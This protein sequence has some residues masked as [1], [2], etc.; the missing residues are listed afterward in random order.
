M[1][2]QSDFRGA[3]VNFSKFIDRKNEV[4]SSVCDRV[5]ICGETFGQGYLYSEL[6]KD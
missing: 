3:P 4:V 5:C 1:D 6:G 2:I